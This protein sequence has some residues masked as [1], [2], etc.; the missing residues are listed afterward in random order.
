MAEQ[1]SYKLPDKL[2][3]H[4]GIIMDGNGRWAKNKGLPRTAGHKAGV[5]A[6]REIVRFSGDIGLEHLT[7]YAFSTENWRRPP[8]EINF[9][10]RLMKRL[11]RDE[12]EDLIKNNVKLR[13]IGNFKN[14]GKDMVDEINRAIDLTKNGTGLNLNLALSYGGRD[15]IIMAVNKIIEQVKKGEH[16][17]IN[18]E[19][20]KHYLFTEG[21]P[22]PD[23]II[24]T[25]GEM[26]VS[27][28]LIYQGAYAEYYVT[29][30]FWPNF[31]PEE[32]VKAL[33]KYAHRTRRF[34]K[35]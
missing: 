17:E 18:E 34:G 4:V 13:V 3:G 5:D 30:I 25:S 9:L 24:R 33:N 8:K 15:E 23:L 12:V 2:P 28:F 14:M 6:A 31:S 7:L 26:R 29:D 10:M 1:Q 21:L 22:D 20:F 35:V 19:S 32:F 16:P 11:L 27:N